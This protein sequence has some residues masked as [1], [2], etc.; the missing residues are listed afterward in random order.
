MLCVAQIFLQIFL[1]DP[2]NLPFIFLAVARP[3]F[4]S[5]RLRALTGA[6]SAGHTQPL[7]STGREQA[8]LVPCGCED[9][10]H[11]MSKQP[12]TPP[13]RE[14]VPLQHGPLQGPQGP[15]CSA[16]SLS[17]PG[18]DI[19]HCLCA[20]SCPERQHTPRAA[21]PAVAGTLPCSLQSCLRANGCCGVP[22]H[23]GLP[24]LPLRGALKRERNLQGILFGQE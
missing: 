16:I 14:A 22:P 15:D 19:R 24:D 7:Y 3:S 4:L 17:V 9:H 18:E 2:L 20:G 21:G 23:P 11:T 13:S 8:R 5:L 6:A 12:C 10:S 1:R